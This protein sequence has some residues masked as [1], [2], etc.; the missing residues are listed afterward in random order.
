MKAYIPR[1]TRPE[2]GNKY[3]ITKSKGG[4]ST[5]IEGSP[6]DKDCNVLANCVGYALGRFNEIGGYGKMK[7]LTP[8]NA[9]V[10]AKY[11]AAQGLKIGYA[12]KLGACMCW[13]KGDIGTSSD[14]AGHVAIV[15]KINAD[16]SI[17]TSES[18]WNSSKPFTTKTRKKG[19][20]NWGQNSSYTFLGFIYQP[21]EYYDATIFPTIRKGSKG[22]YVKLLQTSLISL[23]Y[24]CGKCCV[25]GDFGSATLSAVKAFQKDHGLVVDGIVGPKT[26][27]EINKKL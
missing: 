4:Y 2:A 19:S 18:G 16:G 3:Y 14:G 20:G 7:Y 10:F 26:W 17:T 21:E 27:A 11:A 22:E 25:D 6:T 1:T 23:G 9:E 5:A 15:E 24:S 13:A 12:P 8:K